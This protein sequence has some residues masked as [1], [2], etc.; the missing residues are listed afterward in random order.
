[1]TALREKH[2]RLQL[3]QDRSERSE[4]SESETNY[5]LPRDGNNVSSAASTANGVNNAL[6]SSSN[7]ATSQGGG[8]NKSARSGVANGSGGMKLSLSPS[9]QSSCRVSESVSQEETGMTGMGSN[10]DSPVSRLRSRSVFFF[11]FF[12]VFFFLCVTCLLLIQFLFLLMAEFY[13]LFTSLLVAFHS[14]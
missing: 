13:S 7:V 14:L 6:P 10:A 4:R 5:K 12:F 2:Q 8:G 11:F 9:F 1:M 3:Q